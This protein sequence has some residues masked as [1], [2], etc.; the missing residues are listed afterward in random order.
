MWFRSYPCMRAC[1]SVYA[2]IADPGGPS[3]L[4]TVV[5]AGL[6]DL[7]FGMQSIPVGA[8]IPAETVDRT[9]IYGCVPS[10]VAMR[11]GT[12]PDNGSCRLA[13]LTVLIVTYW[14]FEKCLNKVTAID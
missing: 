12:S 4:A 10:P 14:L 13:C 2:L 6:N 11:Q 5:A 7:S 1:N 8:Y 3:I 9:G